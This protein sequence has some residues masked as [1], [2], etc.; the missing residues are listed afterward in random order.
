MKIGLLGAARIAPA[1][2]MRPAALV[3][4]V[5]VAAVA[6]R[7]AAHAQK[8]A[9]K[10]G[11]QTV[12]T[13][14]DELLARP[15]IDAIYNPLP[16]GLHYEWTLKA[17][18]A[19]KHVLCEKPLSS[20]ADEARQMVA[21][22]AENDRILMTAYHYQFH[23]LAELMR[24]AMTQLG[25]IES[26][27]CSMCF[28]LPVFSD[29]RYQFDLAGGATMDVGAYTAHMLLMLARS[30]AQPGLEQLPEISS[31]SAKTLRRDPRVDRA[32]DVELSW[33]DGTRGVIENSM[34]SS[35]VLKFGAEVIGERGS[36]NVL[37]PILPQLYH[38]YKLTIDGAVR[39]GKVQGEGTYTVQMREFLRRVTR[40][41]PAAADNQLAVDAMQLIDNIYSAAKLPLRG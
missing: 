22:A 18:A 2:L 28:P 29:I 37:N 17:L 4:G 7:D 15:D 26:I 41:D 20:N 12:C 35:K 5:T 9:D 39:A 13:G 40:H 14:Y 27:R 31:A 1:A 38:R 25:R 24:S 32:M 16:N 19:G 23:P 30:S 6:A 11:I 21:A 3:D 10:H 33:A 36:L 8:F 34:W